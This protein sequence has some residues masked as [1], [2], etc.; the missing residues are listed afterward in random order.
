MERT[1]ANI[2]FL[3]G[4]KSYPS[5]AKPNPNIDILKSIEFVPFIIIALSIFIFFVFKLLK[6]LVEKI[7]SGFWF[8][9]SV[10]MLIL[11]PI[12]ILFGS[13]I[14]FIDYQEMNVSE[15]V[16]GILLFV[17]II[18]IGAMV[19]LIFIMITVCLSEYP[20]DNKPRKKI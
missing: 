7:L 5:Y 10:L 15:L 17:M 16:L 2:S 13:V 11:I 8:V 1:N 3:W 18:V 12:A 20:R 4:F 19:V 6:L 14:L 9:V